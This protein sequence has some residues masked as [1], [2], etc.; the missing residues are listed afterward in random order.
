MPDLNEKTN[1][2]KETSFSTLG[3][4]PKAEESLPEPKKD[5]SPS[6]QTT[7]SPV[8]PQ[9]SSS[10]SEAF[11][12]PIAAPNLEV[13]PKVAPP[14]P[15][16][17]PPPPET[18]ALAPNPP[19]E[20]ETSIPSKLP[21]A[22]GGE[23][24]LPPGV[25]VQKPKPFLFK[26]ITFVLI[27]G[28]L[29]VLGY[30]G[31]KF[32]LPLLP[33]GM[34]PGG[35]TLSYWGLWEDENAIRP[36][37]DEYERTHR[38]VKI[39]YK[40]QQQREY[41][42][43]LQV[44]LS[45]GKGPDIFRFHNTWL[46]MFKNDLAFVPPNIFS[47]G[48]FQKVFYPIAAKDLKQGN[49]LYGIPL[50][51]DGLAILYNVDIFKAAGVNPPTTWEDLQK[52]AHILTVKDRSNKIQTAGLA[53]GT[54]NNVDHWSDILGLMLLQN[55]VDLKSPQSQLAEDALIFYTSFS[56]G[57]G[58]T[59]NETLPP[60]TLAFTQ[61]RVAMIFAPSWE[62]LAIKKGNPQLSFKVLPVPQLPG[63]NISWA[64]YWVEGVSQKSTH[65]AAAWDFLNYLSQ[66]DTMVKFYTELSKT[67]LFGEPYS[68]QD[69]G[70]SLKDDPY[71]APYIHEAPH[72]QSFYMAS[73]TF[74]NGIN[75]KIIKYFEDAVNAVNQGA[76]PRAPLETV[77][78]GIKQVMATYG[79]VTAAP[80]PKQ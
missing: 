26:I 59:W 66:K 57:E 12:S 39:E 46:P 17:P 47:S 36:I 53:L 27:I 3:T 32:V 14:L 40:K 80:L 63:V 16:T 72:A 61:G 56:Q 7:P 28:L 25:H 10:L 20:T 33:A 43:R 74:D 44:V 6:P 62:I 4:L 78:K 23:A 37:L 13:K 71:L 73:A 15:Q 51:I 1:E 24:P 31:W 11:P 49:N 2:E 67:R 8:S 38:G 45:Q 30:V 18:E 48:D 9:I 76:S 68:R 52:A 77:T 69:L 79:V 42:E 29:G 60:S 19:P 5:L 70:A 50:E 41:R 55:G 35:V 58:K 64:S 34:R 22:S 54:T 21:T 75:D 65:Q